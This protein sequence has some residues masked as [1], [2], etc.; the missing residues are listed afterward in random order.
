MHVLVIREPRGPGHVERVALF[1][2]LTAGLFAQLQALGAAVDLE[3]KQPS[4]AQSAL[5]YTSD[6]IHRGLEASGENEVEHWVKESMEA[7]DRYWSLDE[8]L[9]GWGSVGGAAVARRRPEITLHR[10]VAISQE[11][12]GPGGVG[13][14]P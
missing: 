12:T 6:K 14:A 3:M 13:A 5:V 10:D 7:W 9:G 4:G 8:D 2:E 11:M 1:D